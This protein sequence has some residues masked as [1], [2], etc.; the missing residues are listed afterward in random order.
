MVVVLICN[1][2]QTIKKITSLAITSST[3][4]HL[5]T[6]L[7]VVVLS[8][9]LEP[10]YCKIHKFCTQHVNK[11]IFCNFS[12]TNTRIIIT[13]FF[14][15]KWQFCFNQQFCCHLSLSESKNIHKTTKLQTLMKIFPSSPSLSLSFHILSQ[16][17]RHGANSCLDGCK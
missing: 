16:I 6:I 1:G 14:F 10:S 12:S 8:M 7:C 17:Y 9:N 5:S 15:E 4:T 13:N 3:C 2:K 11:A